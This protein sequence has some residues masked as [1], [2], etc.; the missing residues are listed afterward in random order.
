MP[1]PNPNDISIGPDK[2][3]TFVDIAGRPYAQAV[4]IDHMISAM[5]SFWSALETECVAGC[6]GI[7]AFSLWPEDIQAVCR[8]QDERSI[9]SGLEALLEFIEKS[10]ADTFVSSRL[11]NLFDKKG[12][13]ELIQHLQSYVVSH[14]SA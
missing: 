12:L 5:E 14:K 13:I 11:N 8:S 4:S 9:A 6:C 10:R 2:W 7:D 3:I 1:K